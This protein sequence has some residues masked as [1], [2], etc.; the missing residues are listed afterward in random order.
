[1]G[2]I[3]FDDDEGPVDE[4]R[5]EIVVVPDEM[6]REAVLGNGGQAQRNHRFGVVQTWMRRRAS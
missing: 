2:E 6:I 3:S 4:K 5:E 1:M